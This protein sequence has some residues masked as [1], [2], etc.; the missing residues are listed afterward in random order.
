MQKAYAAHNRNPAAVQQSSS[1]GIFPALARQVL[2]RG[3]AVYGAAVQPDGTVGYRC[4]TDKAELPAL[5]GSK[6]VF[7]PVA[8]VLDDMAA[9]TA[10]GQPVLAVVSP[11]QATAVR[12]ACGD[13]EH[14][15]LVDF[16]CHG[17]PDAAFWTKY[18]DECGRE[19]SC[20]VTGVNFRK[21]VP[22][23]SWQDY[24]MELRY[25]DGTV[26]QTRAADDPYM[27][28]FLHNA[29]LRRACSLC[30]AKGD[31]RAS[32]L[33]L[34]DFWGVNKIIPKQHHPAGTSLVF[35]NTPR[36]QAAWRQLREQVDSAEVDPAQAVQYNPAAVRA[37]ALHPQYEAFQTDKE[38]LSVRQL[39][40]KYCRTSRRE[41]AVG[42]L[43]RAVKGLL[44]R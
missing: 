41:Q 29:S 33:T 25:A 4:V 26:T 23:A 18:L 2:E 1:G 20:P 36:G 6:Y 34:G 31:N 27:K 11:C 22:G 40:D 30:K 42:Q 13:S 17:A 5:C 15:L 14:L 44:R 37:A 39:A 7:V 10:A 32:D 19:H 43:K 35:V 16:V 38:T 21:K 28:A 8:P 12:R 3:G 9:R 24:R